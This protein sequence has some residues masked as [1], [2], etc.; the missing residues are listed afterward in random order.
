MRFRRQYQ[1]DRFIIDFYCDFP[2]LA[3]EVDGQVHSL[4]VERDLE[5]DEIL[6]SN[7]IYVLRIQARTVLQFPDTA[8]A[9]IEEQIATL[10]NA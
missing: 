8:V 5:R 7:G 4:R 10:R 1:V 3:V 9:M 2:K 6:N